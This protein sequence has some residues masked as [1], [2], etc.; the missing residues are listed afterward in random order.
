M[1]NVKNKNLSIL[2]IRG[3][4]AQHGGFETF[5]QYLSLYLIMKGWSVTVYCQIKKSDH[6]ELFEDEWNGVRRINIPVG[7]EGALGTVIFDLKSTL[8]ACKKEGVILTLGYNT[9]IFSIFYRMK[10]LVNITNMDGIEW[11]RQKWSNFQ[12]LWLYMNERFGCWFSN[13]LVA[14]HPEIKKHLA[15]RVPNSK[16]TMIP[17][18]AESVSDS[19]VNLISKYGLHPKEYYVVIARPEPENS[20]LEI[21]KAFSEQKQGLNLVVLGNYDVDSNDYHKLVK[22]TAS[23]DVIFLGAIYE[24]EVVQAL[25]YYS[26]AYIHGHTVGGTN[27][28]L[29]EALGCACPVIAHDNKFNRWVANDSAVY[30]KDGDDCKKVFDDIQ[31]ENINLSEMSLKALDRF[32]KNFTWDKILSEYELLLEKNLR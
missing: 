31:N 25:R 26:K 5:A 11:S 28:S 12:K 30:F 24:I 3:I 21:V 9:S 27:P 6:N 29:I 1:K 20:I 13:H 23:D 4:P 17:Y 15:T 10:K 18:G 16:I 22:D 19:N 8:H 14:D 7:V 32:R 2:G